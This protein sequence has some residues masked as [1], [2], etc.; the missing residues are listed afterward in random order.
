[1]IA[2]MGK[3]AMASGISETAQLQTR[4]V[5]AVR[6]IRSPRRS[7]TV[8]A[9]W[10]SAAAS[11]FTG[12]RRRYPLLASGSPGMN[13]RARASWPLGCCNDTRSSRW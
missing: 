11:S 9:A 2:Q 6:P 12:I 13:S 10:G 1:M 3:A 4:E 8:D 7:P 5:P